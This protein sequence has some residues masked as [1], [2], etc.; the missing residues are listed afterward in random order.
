VSHFLKITAAGKPARANAKNHVAAI[1][2]RTGLMWT[3]KDVGTSTFRDAA[4]LIAKLNAET[5]A[6]FADWR[7]PTLQELFAI[8]DHGRT[9]PA[10]D[11]NAFPTCKGDWYWTSI[12]LTS[13]PSG[14]A[15]LV[16]FSYGDA[17][18]NGQYLSGRV[19][20]VRSVSPSASGQ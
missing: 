20:A 5:F 7:L 13:S 4:V 2:Q 14:Y 19:R 6:G 9:S 18:F 10:I 17:Y 12:P 16:G 11:T 3:A 8:V 1:D 15:W